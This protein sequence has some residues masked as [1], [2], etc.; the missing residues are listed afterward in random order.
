MFRT[1][2]ILTGVTC[3]AWS[4]QGTRSGGAHI[5]EIPHHC[6]YAERIIFSERSL[7]DVCFFECVPGYPYHRLIALCTTHFV[8]FVKVGPENMGW[9]THRRR[10]YGALISRRTCNW[11]GPRTREA[12][13]EAF[14]NAFFRKCRAPGIAFFQDTFEERWSHYTDV[15]NKRPGQRACN[16]TTSELQ[17]WST[18]ELE[19]AMFPPGFQDRLKAWKLHRNKVHKDD[20]PF[21]FDSD[22]WPY[23]K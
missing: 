8:F 18:S 1:Q 7:E 21:I 22:H 14:E 5:S 16:F 10:L 15:V 11:L 19:F 23:L 17:S 13:K 9:P 3:V 2:K 20:T 12:V 6:W 4:A